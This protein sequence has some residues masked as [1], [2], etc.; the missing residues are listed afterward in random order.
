MRA[1]ARKSVMGMGWANFFF[2]YQQ[3]G[4]PKC[5]KSEWT[6]VAVWFGCTGSTVYSVLSP[7]SAMARM[8]KAVTVSR[9]S[10]GWGC[11][12]RTSTET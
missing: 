3:G 6:Q 8:R 7:F 2:R 11:R 4:L 10:A 9:G 1:G 12:R 5:G